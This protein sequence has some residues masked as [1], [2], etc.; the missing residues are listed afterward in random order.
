M[1]RIYGVN[2]VNKMLMNPSIVQSI[3]R[4]EFKQVNVIL[5]G[6]FLAQTVYSTW[7]IVELHK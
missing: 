2:G 6:F 4:R 3:E 5:V 7:L 1:C